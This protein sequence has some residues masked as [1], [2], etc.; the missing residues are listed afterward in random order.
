MILKPPGGAHVSGSVE[1]KL[2]VMQAHEV[3]YTH[4]DLTLNWLESWGRADF[5]S[6]ETNSLIMRAM[7]NYIL[8]FQ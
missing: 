1:R 3:E 8:L 5:T 2:V 7:T 4:S 6:L